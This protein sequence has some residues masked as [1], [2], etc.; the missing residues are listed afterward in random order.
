MTLRRR[1]L[2]ASG[3][4]VKPVRRTRA[5]WARRSGLIAPTRSEGREME[6]CMGARRSI[7]RGTR[8][9]KGLIIGDAKR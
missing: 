5:I 7:M 6:V 3:T 2:P 1:S 4:R 8:P 9:F